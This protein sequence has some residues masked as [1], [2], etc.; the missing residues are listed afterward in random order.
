M[1]KGH[2]GIFFIGVSGTGQGPFPKEFKKGALSRLE[3]RFVII[4]GCC[5]VFFFSLIGILSLRKPSVE[6]SDKEITRIQERYARLVLNQPK[7]K[8]EKEVKEAKV[9]TQ[10]TA[11]IKKEEKKEEVPVDREKETFVE[12]QK[13]KVAGVEQ[14]KQKRDDVAKQVKNE[15]IF[16]AITAAGSGSGVSV[17]ASDLLGAATEEVADLSGLNITKGTF[18]TQKIHF[19]RTG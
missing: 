16:A 5:A 4:L 12:K 15:G 3:P 9:A 6:V 8:I 11:K 17:S 2:T 7:P 14:R 10:E 18:A 13:R 19:Y 1:E